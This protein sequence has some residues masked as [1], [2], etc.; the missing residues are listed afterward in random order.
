MVI[1]RCRW[2]S[3]PAVNDFPLRTQVTLQAII[4]DWDI[5]RQA[6]LLQEKAQQLLILRMRVS[7]ELIHLVD[8]Y[9]RTLEG[10]VQRRG[11]SADN[12][13][14]RNLYAPRLDGPARDTVRELDVLEARRQQLRPQPEVVPPVTASISAR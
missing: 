13:L 11:T 5:P 3:A 7:Q 1:I 14:G 8:D 6:K 10:Y 9:R 12:P 2:K 4:K